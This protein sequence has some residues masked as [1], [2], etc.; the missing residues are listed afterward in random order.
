MPQLQGSITGRCTQS[1][2]MY[3]DSGLAITRFSI[4]SDIYNYKTKQ[5]DTQ[6]V[7][8]TCFGSIAERINQHAP[9]GT[10]LVVT[11]SIKLSEWV[12]KDGATHSNMEL[13]AASVEIQF[14]KKLATVPS[15]DPVPFE[16]EDGH[17]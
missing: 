8:V 2:M 13:T 6:W 12:G 5:R 3:N 10:I 15:I 16:L 11:G 4:P 1:E 14:D 9:K 7:K 17:F